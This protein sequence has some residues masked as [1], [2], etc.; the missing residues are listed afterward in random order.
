MLIGSAAAGL[1]VAGGG[2]AVTARATAREARIEAAYPPEGDILDVGGVPVHAVVR[3][4]GPDLVMIHGASGNARE[5]TFDLIARLSGRYRCIAFDRPGLGYTG[6]TDPTYDAAFSSAAETPA[7]QA[8]L[9]AAAYGQ[10]GEGA[11]LVLGHSF[12]GTVALAWALDHAARGLVLLAPAAMRWQG[13]LGPLY[14]LNASAP[15]GALAIPMMT[16]LVPDSK[17]DEITRRIFAPNPVPAGYLDH[18]GGQLT[19]RRRSL[20]ANARQVNGLKPH[21]THMQARYASDLTLPIE[22]LHGTVDTIVPP[23]V[24]AGPFQKL[25]PH[26]NLTM[27]DGVGHMPQHAAPE[28]VVA[29]VDRLARA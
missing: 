26:T 13:G 20:R 6:R 24:H 1:A 5:F 23:A 21:I 18:I 29:A 7:E 2:L 11:P 10:I 28:A 9:L 15:G 3:G 27:L 14:A 16:A 22:W 17:L 4:T 19:L 12:G 8:T 25:V